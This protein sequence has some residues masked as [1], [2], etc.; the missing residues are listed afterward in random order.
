MPSP[1]NEP[2]FVV[3]SEREQGLPS[4]PELFAYRGM[5]FAIA[6][7]D[8][9]TMYRQSGLGML[10]M[11]IKPFAQMVA[12]SILFGRVARMDSAGLPYPIFC[13]AVLVPWTFFAMSLSSATHSLTTSGVLFTK[14]RFPRL[15]MPMAGMLTGVLDFLCQLTILLLMMLY[16]G[17]L[18][19]WNV[20]WLPFFILLMLMTA[21]GA[22]LLLGTLNVKFR[23]VNQFMSLLLQVWMFLTPVVYTSDIVPEKW[24]YLYFIN[25]MAAVAKGFRWAL[26]DGASPIDATLCI[27]VAS[28]VVIFVAGLLIFQRLNRSFVDYLNV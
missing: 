3:S 1:D 23:D 19:T 28:T 24:L 11:L 14:V 21:F 10:W 7:R 12:F 6:W 17:I 25:P 4:I 22:G 2:L 18:P 20:V 16:Y 27:S 5:I 13:F 26:L 9:R 15:V 8:I